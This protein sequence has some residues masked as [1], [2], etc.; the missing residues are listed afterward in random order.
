[1]V[2]L[3]AFNV[4]GRFE[5][6]SGYNR[7]II[8]VISLA[9]LCAGVT[10]CTYNDTLPLN[11]LNAGLN[12]VDDSA[13]CLNK[14]QIA[15]AEIMADTKKEWM[16][17][18]ATANADASGVRLFAYKMQKKTLNCA[19]LR[20]GYAEATGARSRLRAANNP[21]LKPAVVSRGAMLG[22]EVALE[23]KRE[24]RKRRCKPA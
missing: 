13:D 17:Q 15:L 16:E 22:D 6:L 19:Q 24:I 4:K 20:Q 8:V 9:C 21:K 5:M 18:P 1:M 11:G 14:R 7:H 23:L 2:R 12:C 10:A 3:V